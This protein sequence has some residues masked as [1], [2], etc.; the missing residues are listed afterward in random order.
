VYPNELHDGPLD[1]LLDSESRKYR[2]M[3]LSKIKNMYGF[4]GPS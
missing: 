1:D 4:G 2:V 3:N